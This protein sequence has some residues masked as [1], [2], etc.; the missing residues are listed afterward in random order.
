MVI[1]MRLQRGRIRVQRK[2]YTKGISPLLASVLLIAA[3]VVIST[4]VAGWVS[5][6]TSATQ[7]TITNKTN[8]GVVCAA[9]E[10]VIDDVYSGAGSGGIA[11]AIV[12]NSGGSDGL[13][14]ISAQLYDKLG[15]NITS[16]SPLPINLNKGQMATINFTFPRWGIATD[17]SSLGINATLI[18]GTNYTLDGRYGS[19]MSFDQNND[20]INATNDTRLDGMNAVTVVSWYRVPSNAG[21]AVFACDWSNL[22]SSTRAYCLYNSPDDVEWYVQTPGNLSGQD[23]NEI[24]GMHEINTWYH[25]AG[26]YDSSTGVQR[27][28]INGLLHQTTT[29]LV[30]PILNTTTPLF[31]GLSFNATG[32]FN[33][34]CYYN[35]ILDDV[36][37]WNRSLTNA[38]INISM[39][40]GPLAVGY[41]NDL[42][43]Y[44][45]FDEGRGVISCPSD[46]SRVVVTTNCGGVSAEFSKRP[47]C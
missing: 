4:M 3:T 17:Y 8:E 18:N 32:G 6:T 42:I 19:G 9:A 14:I 20:Y 38:E 33:T 24:G 1:C 15:N 36:A 47:K 13:T 39:Y 11:R 31:I 25:A 22:D 2:Y 35:G 43:A 37:I 12:R 27:V 7:T 34:G 29:G 41:T 44:W 21:C 23:A 5:S 16:S 45:N 10:I 28:Y 26:N 40:S 30:G 46:F